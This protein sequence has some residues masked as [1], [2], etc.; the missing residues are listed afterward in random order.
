MQK[1]IYGTCTT[2]TRSTRVWST[3]FSC[4]LSYFKYEGYLKSFFSSSSIILFHPIIRIM[5]KLTINFSPFQEHKLL[6]K[7][8]TIYM[9]RKTQHAVQHFHVTQN[10]REYLKCSGFC[11]WFC[12]CLFLSFQI[13]L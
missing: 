12:L 2:Q 11:I 7:F 6:F 10:W 9:Y 3:T 5:K 4:Y 13:S 8:I 1:C